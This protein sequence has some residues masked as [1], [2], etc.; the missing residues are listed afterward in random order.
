MYGTC[1]CNHMYVHVCVVVCAY[2]CTCVLHQLPSFDT[3][4][5]K[6]SELSRGRSEEETRLSPE[7]PCEVGPPAHR[8]CVGEE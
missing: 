5:N 6:P 4:A 2:M 1:V 7:T 3:R 8:D